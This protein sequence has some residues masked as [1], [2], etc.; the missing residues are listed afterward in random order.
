VI[1]NSFQS[2][3]EKM[4]VSELH[5]FCAGKAVEP[6]NVINHIWHFLIEDC[7]TLVPDKQHWEFCA[8]ILEMDGVCKISGSELTKIFENYFLDLVGI[9]PYK[10]CPRC[11][12]NI[13][14]PRKSPLGYFMGCSWYPACNF[15]ATPQ[16]KYKDDGKIA[17]FRIIGRRPPKRT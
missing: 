4:T 1:Y 3:E 17:G 9:A 15:M 10:R 2:R 11:G 7:I 16:K 8:E 14:L 5:N 6:E 13:T 12:Q